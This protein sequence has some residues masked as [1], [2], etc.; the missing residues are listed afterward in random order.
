MIPRRARTSRQGGGA[1]SSCIPLALAAI[2]RAAILTFALAVPSGAQQNPASV[3]TVLVTALMGGFSWMMESKPVFTVDR[4]P[5]GWPNELLPAPPLRSVGGMTLGM[6]HAAVFSMPRRADAGVYVA[7]L[8]RL[9]YKSMSQLTTASGFVSAVEAAAPPMYCKG[10]DAVAVMA[11]DST[12]T[13]R[14]ISVTRYTGA[15][16]GACRAGEP[17]RERSAPLKIPLLRSPPGATV[18]EVGGGSSD[19]YVERRAQLDTTTSAESVMNHYAAELASAGWTVG[20]RTLM[21]ADIAVRAV[22]ARDAEGKEWRG[23]LL[24]MSR[25]GRRDLTLRVVKADAR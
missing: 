2:V 23:M 11:V 8:E 13:T 6:L 10:P 18:Q 22:S 7:Q 12:A 5:A 17:G 20:P 4:P 24:M 1:M 21:D 25:A 16:A 3:P 15:M 9:G 14:W 19:N